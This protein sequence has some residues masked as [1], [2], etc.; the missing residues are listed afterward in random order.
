[1][2]KAALDCRV[3]LIAYARSLLGDY[4]AADDVVQEAMLV[5]TKKFN[6]FQQGTSMLAWCRA[7]VRIEVLRSKQRQQ[8][9]RSLADRLLDD[10]ITG[11]FDEFQSNRRSGDAECWREALQ[12]CLRRVP[13]RG[14]RVLRARFVDE[15]SYQQIGERVGMTIEAVRKTLFRLKKQIRSC[16][17]TSLRT[18]Q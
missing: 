2:L 4:A 15:L 5:V 13:K 17:E 12:G 10:A 11:A 3:E 18:A 16:V 9:E 6:E 1:V 14:R 8:R 7:I